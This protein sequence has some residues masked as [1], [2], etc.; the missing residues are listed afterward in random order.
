MDRGIQLLREG[1]PILDPEDLPEVAAGNPMI[2]GDYPEP[3]RL[4][5][6]DT[7]SERFE[8]RPDY[9]LQ[10][11]GDSMDLIGFR[12]GDVV[13]VREGGDPRNGDVVVARIRRGNYA[14]AVLPSE[15]GRQHRAPAGQQQRR[16]QHDPY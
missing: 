16:A 4:H 9:F 15:R 8:S 3:K 2:P 13:A 7:L 14:Q 1:A 10:V 6:F 11:K 5:D 12:S